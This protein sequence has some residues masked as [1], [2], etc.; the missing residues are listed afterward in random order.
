MQIQE[1]ETIDEHQRLE[2][3]IA[4]M[5]IGERRSRLQTQL[6]NLNGA[7]PSAFDS[8]LALLRTQHDAVCVEWN[9]LFDQFERMDQQTPEFDTRLAEWEKIDERFR[10]LC[11]Q[12][13][14]L[15][16]SAHIRQHPQSE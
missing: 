14:L 6:A 1:T 2:R 3:L 8:Q 15:E 5:P 11:D 7:L 13:D 9:R 4:L 16:L 12:I 10:Q